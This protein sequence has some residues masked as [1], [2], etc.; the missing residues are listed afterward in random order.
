MP[1]D[2]AA[3]VPVWS[4]KFFR[5]LRSLTSTRLA[6][7]SRAPQKLKLPIAPSNAWPMKRRLASRF[8]ASCSTR[9]SWHPA[10]NTGSIK[11]AASRH[12][13]AALTKS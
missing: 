2:T 12:V 1:D 4:V 7:I 13:R 8:A 3:P 10:P 5:D 9:R 6:Y 11:R